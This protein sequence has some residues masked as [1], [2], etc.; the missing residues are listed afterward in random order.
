MV[1][2]QDK[3]KPNNASF[4]RMMKT[5][6]KNKAAAQRQT[7]QA[8]K[9]AK[10]LMQTQA[11]QQRIRLMQKSMR[12]VKYKHNKGHAFKAVKP[13]QMQKMDIA[14]ILKKAEALKQLDQKSQPRLYVF[15]SYSMPNVSILNLYRD[16]NAI[17]APLLIRGLVNNNFKATA[18]KLINIIGT[19]DRSAKKTSILVNPILFK[20]FGIKRV[21]A[22]VFVKGDISSLTCKT[23]KA[24][25]EVAPEYDVV[26]GDIT[27]KKAVETLALDNQD[28]QLLKYEAALEGRL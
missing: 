9:R 18:R 12:T 20:K 15:V 17:G 8:F 11:F 24:C 13:Q 2:A 23:R 27:L 5:A 26:Y 28:P 7:L 19:K 10:V 1:V 22:F 6:E 3:P 21:P 14:S 4:K 25:N 16:A